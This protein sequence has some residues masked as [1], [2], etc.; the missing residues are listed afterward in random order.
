MFCI[1]EVAKSCKSWSSTLRTFRGLRVAAAAAAATPFRSLREPLASEW[2]GESV[3][4]WET[5]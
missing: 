5:T 2:V 4:I 3:L 1:V